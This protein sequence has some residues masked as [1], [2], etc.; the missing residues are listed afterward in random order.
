MPPK[1]SATQGSV[2]PKCR[3][4][5]TVNF[6]SEAIRQKYRCLQNLLS[7]NTE[8]LEMMA[9]IEADLLHLT[10]NECQFREGI[11]ALI[12]RVLLLVQDLDLLSDGRYEELY[13]VHGRIEAEVRQYLQ[14]GHRQESL[15][16]SFPI[17]DITPQMAAEVGGKAANLGEISKLSFSSVPP[18]FVLTAAAYRIFVQA[19][20]LNDRI[21]GLLKDLNLI[22]DPHLFRNRTEEIDLLLRNNPVPAEI[23]EAIVQGVQ[24]IIPASSMWAVRS[25]ALGEDGHLSYAGQFETLLNVPVEKLPDAYRSVLAS[26]YSERAMQY[27]IAAGSAEVDTPMAVLFMPM[28]QARQAGVLYTQDPGDTGSD[29]M[30][31]NAA[32]GLA[33]EIVQGTAVAEGFLASRKMPGLVFEIPGAA[34]WAHEKSSRIS[35]SPTHVKTLV[36]TGL[37][38]EKHFGHPLDIEWAIDERDA[39]VILQARELRLPETQIQTSFQGALPTPLMSGGTTIFPGRSV[40]EAY[41]LRPGRALNSVPET[42][43]VVVDQATPDLAIVLP[44]IAGLLVTFGNPAGHAATLIREFAVPCIFGLAHATS[45]IKDGQL[46]SLDATRRSVY[47]GTLWPNVQDRVRLRIRHPLRPKSSGF[48][49]ERILAL[50]LTDPQA[51]S[52]SPKYCRTIH[53]IIRF[54]HEKAVLTMFDIGD[55]LARRSAKSTAT[56]NADVPLNLRVLNLGGGIAKAAEEKAVVRPD[57]IS[58]LPFQALWRGVTSPGIRWTG[59]NRVSMAGFASVVASS[60]SQGGG[61]ARRGLGMDNYLMVATD[62]LCLNARLAYHFALV[63]A[64]IGEAAENNYVNFRFR[65]G[66]AGVDR[67][68]LRAQFLAQVLLKHNF[69][70][71]RQGDLV[72]AWLRRYPLGPSEQGL[73]LIGRLMGCARQLDMVLNGP[74][75]VTEYAAKF[76]QHDYDSFA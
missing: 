65:G 74:E 2:L 57:D 42:A 72:T 60:L 64:M 20:N 9:D 6:P 12:E 3:G 31:I 46:L 58:S 66:G 49:N 35:L 37:K 26:R 30:L 38:L 4:M 23:Q 39:L 43:L 29:R 13:G 73:E 67:R 5:N 19:D 45:V 18:G 52:F 25:S 76:L 1:L 36:E 22:T 63:D 33:D 28:V 56:L 24:N 7:A 69:G 75:D 21:R 40:G 51:L 61:S 34:D 17:G 44:K 15:R 32:G 47:E 68:S 16:I 70:V 48:L 62:Y 11:T 8:A 50:N 55:N 53:D 71:N 54:V 27:R 59:R 14:A 10:P 41:V